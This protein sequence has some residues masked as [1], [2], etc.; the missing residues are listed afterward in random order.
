MKRTRVIIETANGHRVYVER[1]GERTLYASTDKLSEAKG[2]VQQ[3]KRELGIAR[4]RKEAG[5]LFP[6]KSDA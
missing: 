1:N 3:A 5:G 2:L 6:A 4:G